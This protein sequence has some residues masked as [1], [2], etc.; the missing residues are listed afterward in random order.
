MP[1]SLA[2]LSPGIED[3]VFNSQRGPED[4]TLYLIGRPAMG[5]DLGFLTTQVAPRSRLDA[6]QA[7]KEWR[8]AN[9][10]I[11]ELQVTEAGW[12]D[13]PVSLDLDP[14]VL[15]L[16][17]SLLENETFRRSI[18]VVPIEVKMVELDRLVI[19]QKAVNLSIV[20]SVE[21]DLA[22]NS[23]PKAIFQICMP[24]R[25]PRDSIR[26]LRANND[27]F[28]FV[29]Q[30][31]D[32]RF[33]DASILDAAQIVSDPTR[34]LVSSVRTGWCWSMERTGPWRCDEW[35]TRTHRALFKK[36]PGPRNGN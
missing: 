20:E 11:N 22:A 30:S 7:A 6:K 29:S 35:V 26:C 31:H 3:D 24:I 13:K 14:Q 1:Q 18:E 34:G 9:D 17:E 21:R 15:P 28:V 4:E 36:S 2:M 32:L 23:G 10:V 5:E 19:P 33:L 25:H 8:T 12:A 27:T 16:L